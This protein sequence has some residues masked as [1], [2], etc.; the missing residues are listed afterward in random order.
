MTAQASRTLTWSDLPQVPFPRLPASCPL[1]IAGSLLSLCLLI[2]FCTDS[3]A[4]EAPVVVIG[5]NAVPSAAL[6]T[7]IARTGLPLNEPTTVRKALDELV[8]HEALAAE[9]RRLGYD[10]DPEVEEQTKRLM[11]QKLVADQVDKTLSR[12]PPSDAELRNY[13]DRHGTEFTTAALAHG[14]VA[15][16]LIKGNKEQTLAYAKAA[17]D[18][19]RTNAFEEVVKRYSNFANERLNGGDTG[20]LVADVPNKRYPEEVLKTLLKLDKPGDLTAP[21]VTDKAI[22]LVRLVE[23]RPAQITSFEQAQPGLRSAVERENRQLAYD[24]LCEK[25]KRQ[26]GV[27]VDESVVQKVVEENRSASKPPPAPFRT[28]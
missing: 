9:A 22:F 17:L 13:Y 3:I 26:F 16:L 19:A 10:R 14:Q 25:V 5:T 21:V 4:A 28:P 11:V 2:G 6:R 24:A 12:T 18:L 23:K 20:W 7:A 1:R 8:T 27:K 15:T